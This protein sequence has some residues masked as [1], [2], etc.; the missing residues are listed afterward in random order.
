[1]KN[2][3]SEKELKQ[4]I[5]EMRK[6]FMKIVKKLEEKIENI[7]KSYYFRSFRSKS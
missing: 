6:E 2:Q 5:E 3:Q 4:S 1:M 7:D